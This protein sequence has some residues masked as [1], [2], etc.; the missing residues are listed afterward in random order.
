MEIVTSETITKELMQE[1]VNKA[2]RLERNFA[3]RDG[4]VAVPMTARDVLLLSMTIIKMNNIISAME[5]REKEVPV[6]ISKDPAAPKVKKTY[7]R[8]KKKKDVTKDGKTD[9]NPA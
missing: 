8:T 6:P 1:A 3:N 2:I 7:R 5:L 4:T 9:Q